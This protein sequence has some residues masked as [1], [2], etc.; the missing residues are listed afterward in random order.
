MYTREGWWSVPCAGERSD[1]TRQEMRG[2]VGQ[3]HRFPATSGPL[4][5]LFSCFISSWLS[6]RYQRAI[7]H[8]LAAQFSFLMTPKVV[9]NRTL[10][11][12][13]SFFARL[14]LLVH[15]FFSFPLTATE[16][17]ADAWC[18]SSSLRTSSRYCLDSL[19]ATSSFSCAVS[20]LPREIRLLA[21]AIH[22]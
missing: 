8:G 14:E 7:C 20:A 18:K 21:D 17:L 11:R 22:Q 6:L 12:C 15:V 19:V 10:F 3:R 1:R 13:W 16:S 9:L 2:A 5:C 4:H